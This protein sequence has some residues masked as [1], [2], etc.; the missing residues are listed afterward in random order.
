MR[1]RQSTAMLRLAGVH[2]LIASDEA[3][4]VAIASRLVRDRAW[5]D[6]L[7]ARIDAGRSL[8]FDRPE[9]V[10]AFAQLLCGAPDG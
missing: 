4:Y 8:V 2:E 3:D 9:P 1:G 7:A 10:E 6:E 5:R